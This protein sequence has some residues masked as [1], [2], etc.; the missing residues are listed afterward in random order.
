MIHPHR[1]FVAMLFCATVVALASPAQS[2]SA[3]WIGFTQ[4]DRP[5]QL[6]NRGVTFNR[7]PNDIS[8]WKPTEKDLKST[9]RKSF[10]S[11]LLRKSFDVTKPVRSAEAMICGLGLYELYLNGEKVGDHVLA[12]AQT[13]YDKRVFY[14]TFDITEQ[15]KSGK[16]AVGVML[17]NGFFGQNIAFGPNLGYGAPRT[18]MAIRIVYT[19]DSQSQVQSD[20]SWRASTG[21]ILFD[22]IYFGETFDARNVMADWS[23]AAFQDNDWSPAEIIEA[24]T[25]QMEKQNLEPMRKIR[26]VTPIAVLP[27]EEGW[28]IDMGENMTGWLQIAVEEA[29][30]TSVNLRFAE[31][32]MPDGKNIDTASTGIHATGG[33]QR[34]VYI[35]R[36]DGKETWEPRFTYHGFRYVQVTGVTSKPD[37]N[38]WAGWWVRSD[39]DRIGSFECSDEL[40]NTFYEVSIRTIEG[41]LQG[42]LS[43]CP[44]RERC[45]WMGDMHAVGEAASYNFDL[46]KFWPKVAADIETTLG[47]G[48]GNTR[49]GFPDDPRAP[50]NIAVG[51]RLCGQARPDWGAAT[52]LVPWYGYL[53]YGDLKIVTDAWPMMQGWIAFLDE[54]AVKDGI[55]NDG[56]G[57]WCPPGSNKEIDTP[58]SLTSTALYYQS[59]MAMHQMASAIKK[60]ADAEQYATMAAA[61]Q[62]AFHQKFYGVTSIPVSSVPGG[63]SIVITKAMYGAPSKQ[64]DISDQIQRIVDSGKFSF[65]INNPLIGKDPAPGLKKT[66]QLEYTVDGKPDKQTVPENSDVYFVR[67]SVAGY[68]SQTGSTVALFSGLVPQ[69]DQ[70]AVADGLAAMIMERS[71]G[72]YGTG[73]FGHRPLY[74]QLNDHGHDDVTRHLWR[75]TDWPSLGFMT[76]KHGL[77]TWPE[78]PFDWQPGRR[79]LRNSFNHPMHSGFAATFHESIGG[80]RPD[81]ENPGFKNILLRPTFL[82]DLQWAK[83]SLRSPQGLIVS[84]WKRDNGKLIWRVTIP[85][86]ASAD[87]DLRS[88]EFQN[89]RVNDRPGDPNRFTLTSGK[90]TVELT[91]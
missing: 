23:T 73:I 65:N 33:E 31:H 10:P 51:N 27:A 25:G 64:L 76:E 5:E 81:P 90:W 8:S 29:A 79:Y 37:A 6:S 62:E 83:A 3:K 2:Q 84:D 42:L 34:D 21:P 16:N 48:G 67:S 69:T 57:D 40:I 26:R 54:H 87:V 89:A 15:I 74:T 80:I 46:R 18:R 60:P 53:H 12:P 52:V 68:G 9:P 24:P 63:T 78:V 1:V 55:I 59:L 88:G 70:Q 49:A 77:T 20:E 50:C 47:K 11:P 66:L 56:Y 72:H 7:P 38:Q 35:C 61:V 17:G 45:A 85:D 41:N 32:L 58:A 19:D 13:S 71:N 39:V 75:I 30:G 43:D 28:I 14:N 44:H 4:D 91:E 22:N 82:P 86:G 36:G